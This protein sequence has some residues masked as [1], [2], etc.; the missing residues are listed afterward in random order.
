MAGNLIQIKRS[1]TAEINSTSINST[2]TLARGELAFTQLSNTFWIGAPDGS[3]NIRIGGEQN[4]GILTANQA[5][6][7]NATG[8]LDKIYVS[9]A[10]VG[11]LF[12]NGVTNTG[13]VGQIL[14]TSGDSGNAYWADA[15]ST[16][17]E[18]DYTW[19]GYH[20]FNVGKT[21]FAGNS[22]WSNSIVLSSNTDNQLV[23]G[24]TT[25]YSTLNASS[26]SG[27]SY[28]ADHLSNKTE[29]NLNVNNATT[30]GFATAA[31]TA[32]A[33]TYIANSTA[34]AAIEDI[35]T[36]AGISALVAT[37]ASN[38]ATYLGNSTVYTTL[39]DL[40]TTITANSSAAYTNAM[41]DTLTRDAIF[42]GNS[43]WNGLKQIFNSNVEF[44]ST[45]LVSFANT[46]T[47]SSTANFLGDLKSFSNSTVGPYSLGDTTTPWAG[48]YLANTGGIVFA[49]STGGDAA[50]IYKYDGVDSNYYDNIVIPK[51]ISNA[52]VSN[53]SQINH[54][55][56]VGGGE[57]AI[58]SNA[59]F[60]GDK[61]TVAGAGI[62]YAN[63]IQAKSLS[64]SGNFVVAGTTQTACTE[65]LL[66]HNPYMEL[67]A[68]NDTGDVLDTGFFMK[69]GVTA[70]EGYVPGYA[71]LYREAGSDL[72]NPIFKLFGSSVAPNSTHQGITDTYQGTLLSYLNTGAFVANAS[73][74]N[75]TA[76]STVSSAL[77]INTISLST[78]LGVAS[79]GTGKTSYTTGSLLYAS[80]STT[81]GE[82]TIASA[83]G[84]ANGQVLQIVNN[85][86]AYGTL[87][88]GVF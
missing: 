14:Y 75:I 83:E 6:V 40:R 19:T 78:A 31:N 87:D 57:L 11:V 8:W 10:Y 59:V 74:V 12:A 66:V 54:L 41:A 13:S 82:I 9:N 71:G 27:T 80:G 64:L 67:A 63:N 77:V 24:N 2:A 70:G 4:P 69:F 42:T 73:V 85:L 44:S 76:N 18:L 56:G 55:S 7:A 36:T 45:S 49:N 35:V 34:Y 52:F 60:N 5:L 3:Q 53:T 48:L 20:Q 62:L 47:L 68:D 51:L 58:S 28:S 46:I 22:T 25:V 43:T 88:G 86:P 1:Q 17:T 61:V 81:L 30:A 79:G 84:V 23:I 72:A 16:N 50:V 15:P 29:G 21:T 26:F 32:N 37:L 65:Y 39:S 38:S 33:A